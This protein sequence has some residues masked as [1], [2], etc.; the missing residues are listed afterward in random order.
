M[1]AP[2]QARTLDLVGFQE[3]VKVVNEMREQN[4]ALH[5]AGIVPTRMRPA[6][7]CRD[8]VDALVAEN[9]R[10][11]L[12]SIREAL[13]VARVPITHKPLRVAYPGSP[14]NEDFQRLARDVVS[15]VLRG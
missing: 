6:A 15:R 14:A 2:I 7:L 12:Q 9:G 8:V 3:L 4:A 13:P 1:L 5:I 11:V 10:L